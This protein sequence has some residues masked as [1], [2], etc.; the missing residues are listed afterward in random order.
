MNLQAKKSEFCSRYNGAWIDGVF[1]PISTTNYLRLKFQ[2]KEKRIARKLRRKQLREKIEA[3]ADITKKTAPVYTPPQQRSGTL[4][5]L[6]KKV[7]SF[8]TGRP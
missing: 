6:F 4:F 1:Y 2:R 5:N 8:F 3:T 7:K